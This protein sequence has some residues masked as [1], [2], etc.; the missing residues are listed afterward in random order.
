MARFLLLALVSWFLYRT[1]PGL[2]L[3]VGRRFP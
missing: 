2:V 3:R 1:H